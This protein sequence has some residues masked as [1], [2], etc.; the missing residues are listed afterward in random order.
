MFSL[1]I[2]QKILAVAIIA[3]LGVVINLAFNYNSTQINSQ[4]LALLQEKIFP[5]LE[6]ANENVSRFKSLVVL[7]TQ[8]TDSGDDLLLQKAEKNAAKTI[9]CFK[10]ILTISNNNQ[11]EVEQLIG[12]FKKYYEN[13]KFLTASIVS[14]KASLGSLNGKIRQMQV[15][16]KAYKTQLETYRTNRFEE[17][18]ALVEVTRTSSEKNLLLMTLIGVIMLGVMFIVIWFTSSSISKNLAKVTT[19]FAHIEEGDLSVK[20]SST[21][22]D[23][24]GL[25]I[26]QFDRMREHLSE[27]M[28][29]IKRSSTD[30]SN[31]SSGISSFAEKTTHSIQD[32]QEKLD[33][34]ALSVTKMNDSICNIAVSA[35]N[36][37]EA[38]EEA[39]NSTQSG[40][41]IVNSTRQSIT[42]MAQEIGGIT[43]EVNEL[44]LESQNIGSVLDVIKGV[45]EQTNLLALNAAIE[46]ARAGDQG[47]GFAVV[48][49]EVRSLAHRTQES[50]A[51][52]ETIIKNLREKA[53]HVNHV[54]NTGLSKVNDSVESAQH[55]EQ[56]LA[57]ITEAVATIYDM[58]LD[59]ARLSE[60]QGTVAHQIND[61][62]SE[63]HSELK[64]T[65]G[66]AKSTVAV[67]EEISGLSKT[68]DS[69]TQ[70]FTL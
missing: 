8:A 16:M 2:R 59:I 69:H 37:A 31:H 14:G 25:L 12:S 35:C 61:N 66:S 51:E 50:T 60:E 23:E 33:D 24:L 15:D 44:T 26:N 27:M 47:R 41:T 64:D 53:D 9:A 42:E 43:A 46:A 54:M 17:F 30:L 38:A 3:L 13:A 62:L 52:I 19:A 29:D 49:D 48:A 56:A 34:I 10:T 45:A 6:R 7:F 65:V 21:S 28:R 11:N 36:A 57:S 20:F 39:N 40:Q 58:N 5:I 70:K 55:A 32:Q 22:K 67:C 68:L 18:T 1:S 4:R 63:L